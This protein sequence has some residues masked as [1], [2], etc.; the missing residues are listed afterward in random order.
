M[1]SNQEY[2]KTAYNNKSFYPTVGVN[3]LTLAMTEMQA[4]LGGF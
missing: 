1:M 4:K 3:V 2:L